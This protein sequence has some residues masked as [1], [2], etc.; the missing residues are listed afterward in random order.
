VCASSYSVI[1]YCIH[2][3]WITVGEYLI[4][5]M[6]LTTPISH[7]Y[8]N[9]APHVFAPRSPKSLNTITW[10]APFPPPKPITYVDHEEQGN[11]F[12]SIGSRPKTTVIRKNKQECL[13]SCNTLTVVQAIITCGDTPPIPTYRQSP[14]CVR[15]SCLKTCTKFVQR[16]YML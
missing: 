8:G 5:Q 4:I 2:L 11:R 1:H 10:S 12:K 3:H 15:N 7:S 6:P 14:T 13:V 16:T 9:S